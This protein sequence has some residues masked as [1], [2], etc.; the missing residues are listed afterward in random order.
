MSIHVEY[1]DAL[2]VRE[3]FECGV[4]LNQNARIGADAWRKCGATQ[5]QS[6]RPL[7]GSRTLRV[8]RQREIR[9]TSGIGSRTVRWASQDAIELGKVSG[10]SFTECRTSNQELDGERAHSDGWS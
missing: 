5:A 4:D 7:L 2:D 6:R 3:L 9:S 1:N 10:G 8:Q